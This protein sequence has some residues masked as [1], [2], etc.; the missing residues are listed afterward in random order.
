MNETIVT[1]RRGRRFEA[2]TTGWVVS[3]SHDTASGKSR[4]L[5]VDAQDFSAP[6]VAIVHLPQRV[7]PG[8]HGSWVADSAFN[9]TPLASEVS[10]RPTAGFHHS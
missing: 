7:P 8:A 6:P 10:M 4:L 5:I 1:P 9:R 3:L 2:R